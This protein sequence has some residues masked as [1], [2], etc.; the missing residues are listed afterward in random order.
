MLNAHFKLPLA[1]YGPEIDVMIH[2][3]QFFLAM[4]SVKLTEILFV[5][6]ILNNNTVNYFRFKSNNHD[7]K[8][9]F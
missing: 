7:K 3:T 1:S 2:Q 9:K 8:Y 4:F 6:I 5:I